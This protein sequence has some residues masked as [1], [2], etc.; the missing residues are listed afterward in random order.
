MT[1]IDSSPVRRSLE[2]S[3]DPITGRAALARLLDA[4][5]ELIDE[6]A[7]DPPL[8]DAIVAVTVASRSLLSVLERDRVA[9]EMLRADE[10]TA[11]VGADE[12]V[13]RADA[14]VSTDDPAAALRRWK[15]RQ[16]VRI[17]G[18]DLLGIAD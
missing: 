2:R 17:A 18:R 6:V 3:A 12:L 9:V 14:A 8:L 5:P 4:H 15:H 13:E 7:S 11:E 16:M 10:L 1:V